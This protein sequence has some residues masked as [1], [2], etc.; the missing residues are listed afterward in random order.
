MRKIFT[1]VLMCLLILMHSMIPAYASE[2]TSQKPKE[3]GQ[4]LA[5]QIAKKQLKLYKRIT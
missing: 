4:E 1:L 5:T 3:I 2:Q